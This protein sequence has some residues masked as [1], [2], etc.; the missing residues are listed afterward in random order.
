MDRYHDKPRVED[1]VTYR[2]P[3]NLAELRL[4]VSVLRSLEPGSPIN[5]GSL[6]ES[7][8]ARQPSRSSMRS[9]RTI[10][11]AVSR[12]QPVLNRPRLSCLPQIPR[13]TVVSAADLQFGQPLHETHPHLIAPGDCNPPWTQT[14]LSSHVLT[15][16]PSSDPRYLCSRVSPT[17]REP[18]QS[19]P[20]EHH[21]RPRFLRHQ[22]PI[23]CR[24]LRISPRAKLL[25]L[26]R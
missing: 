9:C 8:Q 2:D 7:R 6:T 15:L 18:R 24:L 17:P 1:P 25:L 19:H 5:F 20:Q 10:L 26:D 13:R 3:R 12:P 14:L 21:C 11:R 4:Q 16:L 23:W 22:V